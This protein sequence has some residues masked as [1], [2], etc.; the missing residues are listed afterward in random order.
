MAELQEK[1]FLSIAE[2]CALLGLS[3]RTAFRLMQSGRIPAVKLGRRTIIK[4]ASLE[5][6]CP[7]TSPS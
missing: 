7:L 4:R 3:R 1:A 6:L 5:A 2:T